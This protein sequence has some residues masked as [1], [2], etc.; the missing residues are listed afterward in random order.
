MPRPD[1]IQGPDHSMAAYSGAGPGNGLAVAL[2]WWPVALVFALAY[3]A[4]IMRNYSGKVRP[5]ED[6]QGF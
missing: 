3:F 4:A 2:L 5:A 6:T 1:S